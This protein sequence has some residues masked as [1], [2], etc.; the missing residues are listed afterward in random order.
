MID[1]LL[2]VHGLNR[3]EANMLCSIAEDLSAL[4]VAR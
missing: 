2:A 3:H 1:Y 4:A